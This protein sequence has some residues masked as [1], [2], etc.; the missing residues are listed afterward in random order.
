[1]TLGHKAVS[2]K[3]SP[4][5]MWRIAESTLHKYDLLCI[6]NNTIDIVIKIVIIVINII[7]SDTLQLFH[8]LSYK[9]ENVRCVT[10]KCCICHHY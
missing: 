3:S 9:I 4:S 10:C 1:M 2:K 8:Q 5:I 6:A 7:N